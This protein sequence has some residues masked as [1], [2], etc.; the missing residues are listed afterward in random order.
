[1]VPYTAVDAQK[2]HRG[3]QQYL[4]VGIAPGGRLLEMVAI[5]DV[6]RDTWHI[7]HAMTAQRKALHELGLL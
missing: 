7:F 2:Q 4:A 5:I 3:T 1:M 6:G